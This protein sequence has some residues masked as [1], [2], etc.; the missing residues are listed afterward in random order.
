M[1]ELG[2]NLSEIV[3]QEEFTLAEQLK[4]FSLLTDSEI[5]DNWGAHQISTLLDYG[6]I[7]KTLELFF[8]LCLWLLRHEVF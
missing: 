1:C 5:K 4:L 2:F 7:L 8:T 3:L 6:T